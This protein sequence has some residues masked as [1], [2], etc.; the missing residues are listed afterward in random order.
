MA[1]DFVIIIVV[2]ILGVLAF[3]VGLAHA[4]WSAVCFVFGSAVAAAG[5]VKNGGLGRA[6][7]CV[8]V[9]TVE[10]LSIEAL[11]FAVSVVPRLSSARLD[12]R[13]GSA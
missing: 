2:L 8:R 3:L 11:S 4:I 13:C 5:R 9:N 1:G 12:G 6:G 7:W 10:R